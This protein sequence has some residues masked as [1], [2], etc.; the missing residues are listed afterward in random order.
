MCRGAPKTCNGKWGRGYAGTDADL[1]RQLG[2]PDLGNLMEDMIT[3]FLPAAGRVAPGHTGPWRT[4]TDTE[5]VQ[6]N[7]ST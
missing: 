3:E 6:R 5:C 2:N 4:K 7:S 1:L